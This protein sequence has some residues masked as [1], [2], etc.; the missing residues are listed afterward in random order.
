MN[1]RCISNEMSSSLK[2]SKRGSSESF[3]KHNDFPLISFFWKE[4]KSFWNC[5]MKKPDTTSLKG[6]TPVRW[7][8][9]LCWV[10]FKL[11]LN[12]DLIIH[13]SIRRTTFGKSKPNICRLMWGKARRGL[14]CRSVR[15]IRLKCDF[16][17]S[18]N[19]FRCRQPIENWWGSTWNFVGRYHFMGRLGGC[20]KKSCRINYFAFTA[21]LFSKG[22]SNN[23][24]VDL[25]VLWLIKTFQFWSGLIRKVF[26]LSMT[27]IA[28][29]CKITPSTFCF[30]IKNRQCF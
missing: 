4:I 8:I 13:K 10:A 9:T 5:C 19:A 2:L 23:Q 25:Q 11:G 1:L 27:S 17:N 18:L 6:A 28:C 16:L 20:Y 3:N 21:Q 24:Y 7:P 12:W 15:R 14:G 29:V 30:I 26:T 22:K